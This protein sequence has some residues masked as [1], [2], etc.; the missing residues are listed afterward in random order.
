MKVIGWF[1]ELHGQ[2]QARG[3]EWVLPGRDAREPISY[4]TLNAALKRLGRVARRFSVHDLRRTAR[5]HLAALGVDVIVCERALNHSLGGLIAIY[6][7]HDY[8][9]ER[10]RAL[11]LWAAFL[12]ACEQG[13]PWNVTPLRREAA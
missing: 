9:P 7:K 12:E 2:A 11:E 13:E 6:D 10:R 4:S 5:T 3:S 1:R 8:L